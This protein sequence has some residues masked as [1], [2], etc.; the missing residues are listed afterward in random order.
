MSRRSFVTGSIL[1]VILIISF[2]VRVDAREP[3]NLN[4]MKKKGDP[5]AFIKKNYVADIA[6]IYSSVKGMPVFDPGSKH[7]LNIKYTR[8]DQP[9]NK[10]FLQENPEMAEECSKPN[11]RVTFINQYGNRVWVD[12]K[13]DEMVSLSL[14]VSLDKNNPLKS[15]DVVLLH[16]ALIVHDCIL[17]RYSRNHAKIFHFPGITPYVEFDKNQN[18]LF[19]FGE[20]DYISFDAKDFKKT[21]GHGFSISCKPTFYRKGT[22]AIPDIEYTGK[23]P[24]L[25]TRNWRYPPLDGHFSFYNGSEK[26]LKVPATLLY[27][28][29]KN[30]RASPRFKQ[31]GLSNYLKKHYG[32]S[33]LVA[34][35]NNAK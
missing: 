21:K 7:R 35:K 32:S 22:R 23:Q 1:F 27:K 14:R 12:I 6:R 31:V 20:K 8:D 5:L 11:E 25:V 34:K 29:L 16:N 19:R 3:S 4:L 9:C 13:G 10:I 15:R 18:V 26:T 33:I 17:D 28:K 30:D 2:A 24:Y